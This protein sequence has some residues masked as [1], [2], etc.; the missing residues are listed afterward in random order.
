MNILK[1]ML[2]PS[3]DLKN[4]QMNAKYIHSMFKVNCRVKLNFWEQD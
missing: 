2:L 4:V 1:N 3:I